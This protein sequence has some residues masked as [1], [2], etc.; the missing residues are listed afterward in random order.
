MV[1]TMLFPTLKP[2]TRP[3]EEALQEKRRKQIA[4]AKKKRA[5][6][7]RL[8]S[9]APTAS[10]GSITV[11]DSSMESDVSFAYS[12]DHSSSESDHSLASFRRS[13]RSM[14]RPALPRNLTGSKLRRKKSCHEPDAPSSSSEDAVSGSEQNEGEAKETVPSD[15]S[16]RAPHPAS[17]IVVTTRHMQ[18]AAR[19]VHKVT[20]RHV[21]TVHHGTVKGVQDATR[22]MQKAAKSFKTG[23][24]RVAQVLGTGSSSA[25]QQDTQ[26]PADME[27]E[28]T[29]G[30]APC[31]S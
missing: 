19:Q 27:R 26:Q 17:L 23:S 25:L 3:I 5:E 31:S 6:A 9:K 4:A 14:S 29:I 22:H 13:L 21:R 2:E 24:S 11:C 28:E 10:D 15:A 1:A 20:T 7:L 30:P 16:Q 18:H 12:A 8:A